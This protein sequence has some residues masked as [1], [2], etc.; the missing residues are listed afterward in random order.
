MLLFVHTSLGS[1]KSTQLRNALALSLD[2]EQPLNLRMVRRQAGEDSNSYFE[3][4]RE[5]RIA[6]GMELSLLDMFF[7]RTGASY[8]PAR[9]TNQRFFSAGFGLL[10]NGLGVDFAYLLPYEPHSPI[11]NTVRVG[12]SWRK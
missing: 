10:F 12:V 3:N 1:V 8:A 4:T 6:S 7:L 9:W 11:A 5:M 2:V